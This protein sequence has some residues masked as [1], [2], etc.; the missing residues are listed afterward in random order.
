MEDHLLKI[1]IEYL[2]SYLT[3]RSRAKSLRPP[4]RRTCS[5]NEDD[6]VY[7]DGVMY[8]QLMQDIT[9]YK[10]LLLRLKRVIQEVRER[11]FCC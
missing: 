6:V 9:E 8:R 10:T 2:L 3:D 4:R 7:I 11:V 1:S 5:L